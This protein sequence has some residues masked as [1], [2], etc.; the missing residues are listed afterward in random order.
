MSELMTVEG[1]PVDPGRGYEPATHMWVD[2]RG[3]VRVG[4]DAL[5][6]ETSGTLAALELVEAGVEGRRGEVFGSLEAAKFV[7]PLL[8][9]VGGRVV[10]VNQAVLEDP[11]LVER[12]PYGHG[13]LVELADVPPDDLAG[14]VWGREAVTA[15]FAGAVAGY[16]AKGVLAE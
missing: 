14:L 5:G 10:A 3:S 15:W 11:G 6:V 1:F 8:L 4:L 7:G 13:W 9:P 12:D 16:R 2:T